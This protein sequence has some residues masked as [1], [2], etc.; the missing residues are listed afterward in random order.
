MVKRALY[1]GRFQPFHLG[2][3]KALNWI[4]ERE[5]EVI[6]CIGSP[7]YSFTV[8]NPFTLGERI[9]MIW[10]VLKEE[11]LT[12]RCIITSVPDTYESHHLWVPLVLSCCPKFEHVYTNDKMSRLLFTEA[13]IKVLSIPFFN[14]DI[15]CATRIRRLMA[16]GEEWR[17]FV[18]PAVARVIDRIR[19]TER[20][21]QVLSIR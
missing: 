19:G 10:E 7:Q 18:H 20:I 4:L 6:I 15:L 5:E 21:R 11:G 8:N 14:R 13:G 12:N 3:L 17:K 16:E 2:H 1:V 9:E